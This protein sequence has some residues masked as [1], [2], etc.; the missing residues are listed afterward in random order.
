MITQIDHVLVAVPDLAAASADYR[1]LGFTVT[2][3]GTHANG[4]THNALVAFADGAYLELIAL[5]N[6]SAPPQDRW[7]EMMARAR[8]LIGFALLTPDAGAAAGEVRERG[9]RTSDAVENGRLRPDG[10]RVAW[11]AFNVQAGDEDE[12]VLPFVI[13][14]VTP[15]GL[16]VPAGDQAVHPLG[17]TRLAGVEVAVRDLDEAAGWFAGLLGVQ[18]AASPDADRR[19]L[20]LGPQWIDLVPLAAGSPRAGIAAITLGG[21]GGEPRDLPLDGTGGARIRV[22][23]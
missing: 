13:E 9:V 16:R 15:R 3:G 21:A 4:A 17:V 6:P 10:E 12:R 19:R 7:G 2:P 8:G 23:G 1:R 18:P 5:V 22:E 20:P 14:D 11:R